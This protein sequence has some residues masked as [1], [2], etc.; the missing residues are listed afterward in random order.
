[1][2]RLVATLSTSVFLGAFMLGSVSAEGLADRRSESVQAIDA[3]HMIQ[4]IHQQYGD[5][6]AGP[7][8]HKNM[9]KPHMQGEMPEG[10]MDMPSQGTM[11]PYQGIRHQERYRHMSAHEFK[12][13]TVGSN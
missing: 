13:D 11:L 8:M 5:T 4:L 10:S 9:D 12:R 2:N 7:G 1:M 6:A 3:R